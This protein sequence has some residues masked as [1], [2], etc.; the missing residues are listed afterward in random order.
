MDGFDIEICGDTTVPTLRLSGELDAATGPEL[1]R[2]L[3]NIATSFDG[4][5]Y[6]APSSAGGPPSEVVLELS[7][8]TFI[9]SAGLSV[10]VASHKRLLAKGS[11]L[12]LEQP[13]AP[14][15]RLFDITGLGD[16]LA[17]RD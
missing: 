5:G 14:T 10:L 8:I 3:R 4:S 9:D 11:A 6:G 16:V 15:R 7:G 13:S 17:I 2:E 12:V 1:E